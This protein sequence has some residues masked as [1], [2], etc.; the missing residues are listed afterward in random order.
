MESEGG[1]FTST[2]SLPSKSSSSLVPNLSA[3]PELLDRSFS[4]PNICSEMPISPTTAMASCS[5]TSSELSHGGDGSISDSVHSSCLK[6]NTEENRLIPVLEETIEPTDKEILPISSES[7]SITK[8]TPDLVLNLPDSENV[9][10]EI[11]KS[12]SLSPSNLDYFIP[13][14]ASSSSRPQ[15]PTMTTAEVFASVGLG[16]IK[17]GTS[18]GRSSTDNLLSCDDDLSRGK[19][20]ESDDDLDTA[21]DGK[22]TDENPAIDNVFTSSGKGSLDSLKKMK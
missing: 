21:D 5:S 2:E 4:Q 19:Q 16:T 14:T 7:Q 15:S 9:P 11:T 12:K 18:L 17:K 3:T 13:I 20:C 8:P 1:I 6:E 10:K 22:E